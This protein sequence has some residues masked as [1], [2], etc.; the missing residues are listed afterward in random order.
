MVTGR[1]HQRGDGGPAEGSPLVWSRFDRP[2]C[3]PQHCAEPCPG[4]LDRCQRLRLREKHDAEDRLW[5]QRAAFNISK[6][7]LWTYKHLPLFPVRA[8][9]M[10]FPPTPQKASMTSWD[11]EELCSTLRAMCSAILSGVTENQPSETALLACVRRPEQLNPAM[12]RRQTSCCIHHPF[13]LSLIQYNV[14]YLAPNHDYCS[15]YLLNIRI[16]KLY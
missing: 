11:S 7:T 14:S 2:H 3:K 13:L 10:A 15:R 5:A 8:N 6:N 16:R 1:P 9:W 4:A 12:R